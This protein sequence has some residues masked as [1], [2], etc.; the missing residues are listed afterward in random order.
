MVPLWE[1]CIEKMRFACQTTK[2]RIETHT[3]IILQ[4]SPSLSNHSAWYRKKFYGN[5]IKNQ[6]TMQQLLW[7]H[8]LFSQT[9]RLYKA[10]SKISLLSFSAALTCNVW[11]RWNIISLKKLLLWYALLPVTYIYHTSIVAHL[12]ILIYLTVIRNSTKTHRMHSC[13]SMAIM[14]KQTY[15]N[16]T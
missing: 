4:R 13:V 2:G 5:T 6:A 10:M 8:D 14:V 1:M 12:N 15:H 7:Y 16:V 9:V 3:F 11:K